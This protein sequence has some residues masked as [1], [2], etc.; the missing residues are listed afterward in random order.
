MSASELP[1]LMQIRTFIRV[2]DHGSVSRASEVLLRAQSVVTRS[3]HDLEARLGV[4]LFQRHANGML[5]TVYGK[6]ILPRARRILAELAVIPAIVGQPP[7]TVHEQL[8]LLYS[9]RLEIFVKLCETQHMQTVANSFG[10][11][12]PAISSALKVLENGTGKTLFERTAKGLRPTQTSQDILYPIRRALNE[13]RHI[14]AD[15]AALKGTLQGTVRVGALPLG[16]TRILPEAIVKLV[17]DHP[18][19]RVATNESPFN[20]LAL[21]LRAGDVDFVFGALRSSDYASDLH[22]EKLLTEEMVILVRSEHPLTKKTVTPGDLR[23]AQWILPRANTPA[24]LIMDAHFEKLG[25][26]PPQP[27]VETGD[28]AIIRGLLLRSDMLAVVSEHQLEH[29]ISSGV[30]QRLPLQLQDTNRA[31][32]LIYRTGGLH[33]PAAEALI[34]YIRAAV[35]RGV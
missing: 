28:L 33:S 27:V 31:I 9:R 35:E 12:Q 30:L 34:E 8:Y 25:D 24:R 26:P 22:G 32:G 23:S 15:I 2:A 19:V 18:E 11:S 21:E 1:N 29:E 13:L 4:Q 7:V 5:L 14:D 10:L 3:I 6:C 17:S 20:L 16:R